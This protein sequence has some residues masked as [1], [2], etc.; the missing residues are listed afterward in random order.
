M[1]INIWTITVIFRTNYTWIPFKN[2]PSKS[3]FLTFCLF[4]SLSNNPIKK[5]KKE[6]KEEQNLAAKSTSA[7]GGAKPKENQVKKAEVKSQGQQRPM[8]LKV[9]IYGQPIP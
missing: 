9:A 7:S 4:F 2:Y 1:L 6:T 8:T 5:T 3:D